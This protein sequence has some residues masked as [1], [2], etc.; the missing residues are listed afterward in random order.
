MG[1]KAFREGIHEYLTE[2]AYGNAT[3]DNLIAL[4]DKRS[5]ADLA[6]FSDTWVNRRGMPHIAMSINND[7]LIVRQRDPYGRALLWQ[8]KFSVEER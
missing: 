1:E 2:F 3:W 5:D 6:A 8:Q 7:T 4:L